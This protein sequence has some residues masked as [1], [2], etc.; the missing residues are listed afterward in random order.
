MEEIKNI[1]SLSIC[2]ALG[3]VLAASTPPSP[4]TGRAVL[5]YDAEYQPGD[6]ICVA[7]PHA[8]YYVLCLEDT[9]GEA[10]VYM[11]G[12]PF[13][14]DIPFEEG[15]ISYNPRAFLLERHYLTIRPATAEEISRPRNLALNPYDCHGS[16]SCFPHARANVETRGESV[17]AARNAI[18]GVVYPWCHGRY[19]FASWGINQNPDATWQIDFGRPVRADKLILTLRADYPHDAWWT[20]ATLTFD[21]GETRR[22]PLEKTPEGQIF[23]LEG[24]ILTGFTLSALIKADDP[25]PFPALTQVELWGENI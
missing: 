5:L 6:R 4:A 22:L 7:V 3:E 2:N 13:A 10:F 1:L 23:P 19:P 12:A 15:R 20:Q 21:D 11:N 17:F 14:L 18:D 16:L 8:G 24:R 9:M 25:S